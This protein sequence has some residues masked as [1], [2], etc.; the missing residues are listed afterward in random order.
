MWGS[1]Q[2]PY[3][4]CY[5]FLPDT[6]SL[7]S[8]SQRRFQELVQHKHLYSWGFVLTANPVVSSCPQSQRKMG[9]GHLLLSFSLSWFPYILAW[10]RSKLMQVVHRAQKALQQACTS[11]V[12]P[13]GPGLTADRGGGWGWGPACVF[14]WITRGTIACISGKAM[15]CVFKGLYRP[16]CSLGPREPW[17]WVPFS[18]HL[19]FSNCSSLLI[20]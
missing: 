19:N 1:G 2:K 4:P 7:T 16:H 3:L 18:C 11:Q 8:G 17:E 20:L 13:V 9:Q 5:A 12:G 14:R 15:D 6:Q 10:P